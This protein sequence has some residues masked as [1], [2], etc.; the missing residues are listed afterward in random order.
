M[1]TKNITL[2]ALFDAMEKNGYEKAK[3][4]YII[5][6]DIDNKVDSACAYGQAALNLN[7]DPASLRLSFLE[8]YV[9]HP[10]NSSLP[11]P[12]SDAI[13]YDNDKTDMSVPEIAR[14]YREI[15]G[16]E[17]E[18]IVVTLTEVKYNDY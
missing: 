2:A 3:G 5:Y 4:D 16:P 10:G 6:N 1:T 11:W 18:S 17:A 9:P 15:V 14:K 12:I 7:V 8:V 13:V